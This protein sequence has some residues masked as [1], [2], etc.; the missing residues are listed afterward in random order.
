MSTPDTG[1]PGPR[2]WEV[3]DLPEPAGE[4]FGPGGWALGTTG[5]AVDGL[6]AGAWGLFVAEALDLLL[7]L[8]GAGSTNAAGR[9]PLVAVGSAIVDLSPAWLKEWAIASFGT[10]DK[11]VLFTVLAIVLAVFF[12]AI[13]MVARTRHT[14]ALALVGALGVLAIAALMTRA[15]A[16]PADPLPL[17]VGLAVTM[18]LL[19]ISIAVAVTAIATKMTAPRRARVLPSMALSPAQLLPLLNIC[20]LPGR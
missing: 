18:W 1:Q 20:A 7:V 15:G 8:V 9:S 13:G 19:V 11:A 3:D 17:A 6:L 4:P 12:A 2:P 5:Y 16:S 14:L 10:G